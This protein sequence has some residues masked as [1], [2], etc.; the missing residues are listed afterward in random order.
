MVITM[1]AE[2]V[3]GKLK[4]VEDHTVTLE[5]RKGTEYEAV[6]YKCDMEMDE[7]WIATMLGQYVEAVVIDGVI[8][9]IKTP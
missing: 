5:R 1:K 6:E 9:N 3:Y 8:K 4:Q 7:D 2:L